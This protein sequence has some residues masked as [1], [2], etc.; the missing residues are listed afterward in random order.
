MLG[1]KMSFQQQNQAFPSPNPLSQPQQQRNLSPFASQLQSEHAYGCGGVRGK[2]LQQT[3]SSEDELGFGEEATATAAAAAAERVSQ[4]QSPSPWQRMKWTDSMVRL[5]VWV[6]HSVGDDGAGVE[7]PEQQ[8]KGKKSSSLQLS[9]SSAAAAAAGMQLKKGKW[10]SVSR[11][12]LEK[13]FYVSPQQCEDK[14]NDLNKRYKRV[15]ELL[16]KGTACKVV[17]NPALLDSMDHL[18]HKAKAE[19]R[20]LLSSKHLFFREMCAYHNTCLSASAAALQPDHSSSVS[21]ATIKIRK[22]GG[23]LCTVEE[24]SGHLCHDDDV[25][26]DEE[27][28]DDYNEDE[29]DDEEEDDNGSLGAKRKALMSPAASSP[30]SLSLSS[31]SGSSSVQGEQQQRQWLRMKAAELEEQRVVYQNRA[32]QL[33]KQ[34]FKWLRFSSNKEREMEKTWLRNERLRLENERMLLLLQQKEIRLLESAGNA[35]G[36]ANGGSNGSY[37]FTAADRNHN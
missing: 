19:A 22:G 1:L 35:G 29:S 17:E 28:E 13:G 32:L 9:S 16:G 37:Q 27:E 25:A 23:S 34:R 11:A 18:S 8:H 15:N 31:P 26:D 2:Q 5:L 10:K 21:P 3:H 33:E 12:M 30:L 14:F 36:D 24:E 4:P 20:K 6:V 7:C